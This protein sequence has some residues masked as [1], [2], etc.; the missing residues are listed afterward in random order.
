MCIIVGAIER[1]PDENTL[2][3]CYQNNNDGIGIGYYENNK[4]CYQKGITFEELKYIIDNIEL[5]FVVHFRLVS[6]GDKSEQNMHPFIISAKHNNPLKYKG[7]DPILFHNGTL[8]HYEWLK[9][10]TG[11]NDDKNT[12]YS[13]TYYLAK[14]VGKVGH[15]IIPRFTETFN[16]IVIMDL[17]YIYFYGAFY[18]EDGIYYSNTGYMYSYDKS[19]L[20]KCS[21]H[22]NVNDKYYGFEY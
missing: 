14:A 18:H 12:S 15:K 16:K 4:I 22:S 7:K 5:P 3:T 10:I 1:K 13:D 20:V 19:R 8:L 11:N 9:L 21:S 17:K 2:L 6:A